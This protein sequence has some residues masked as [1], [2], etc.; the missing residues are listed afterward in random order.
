[1][2]SYFRTDLA[3]R[4]NVAEHWSVYGRV[5]NIFDEHIEEG[6][7]YEQPGVYAVVGLEWKF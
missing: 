6:L 2:D 1:M 3:A 7:G 4:A 5:E